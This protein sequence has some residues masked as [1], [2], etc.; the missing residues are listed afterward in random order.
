MLQKTKPFS[1]SSASKASWK[2]HLFRA[3][4]KWGHKMTLMSFFKSSS[5]SSHFMK[6]CLEILCLKLALCPYRKVHGDIY[7]F[8][9]LSTL[10]ATF[11]PGVQLALNSG[12]SRDH[13]T[14][15]LLTLIHNL[16]RTTASF[17]CRA[18]HNHST[19]CN[20]FWRFTL[21]TSTC[22]SLLWKS[23]CKFM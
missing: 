8:G 7:P 5:G 12:A 21:N 10:T 14:L 19:S 20:Q 3:K 6:A 16:Q 13:S 18:F 22:V 2:K 17:L 23:E 15:T 1:D 4:E 11:F 9:W